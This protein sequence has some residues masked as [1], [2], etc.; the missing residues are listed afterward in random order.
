MFII[1]TSKHL[2]DYFT[3]LEDL[4]GI[5]LSLET[6]KDNDELLSEI[7]FILKN[8]VNELT[9]E[10]LVIVNTIINDIDNYY[11]VD[12]VGDYRYNFT[13]AGLECEI[14]RSPQYG[15]WYG[16]INYP[17]KLCSDE[18]DSIIFKSLNDKFENR[19]SEVNDDI[20][21]LECGN[22]EEDIFPSRFYSEAIYEQKNNRIITKKYR[23]YNFIVNETKSLAEYLSSI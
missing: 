6:I 11:G 22:Y 12:E 15:I 23:D 7:L 14:F 18:S 4:I 8:S 3:M 9:D 17:N 2:Q 21:L 16:L 20:V 1:N 5:G 19:I 13:H 10:H